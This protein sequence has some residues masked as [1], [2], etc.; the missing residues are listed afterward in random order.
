MST[1][2]EWAD[3]PTPLAL[4]DLVTLA[5]SVAAEVAAGEHRYHVDPDRRWARLLRSDDHVDAWLITWASEQRA[6]L[7]DHAG[8]LGALAVVA[9][10]LTEWSWA[11]D[12]ALRVRELGAGA[13]AG[14]PLGHV[15]DVVNAAERPAVSVHVYSPPLTAM[16]YYEVDGAGL[17]RRTS[18]VLTRPA[19]LEVPA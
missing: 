3:G 6:Q 13:A 4:T 1:H 9:G 5:R 7:H 2:C 19:E 11:N 14:F 17:L 16:S 12:L 10:E 8:S 15:H 18:T